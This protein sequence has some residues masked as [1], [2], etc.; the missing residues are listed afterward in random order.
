[1]RTAVGLSFVF[2]CA[3]CSDHDRSI[4]RERESAERP[5]A[6]LGQGEPPLDPDGAALTAPGDLR[7]LEYVIPNSLGTCEGDAAYPHDP[8]VD[9]ATGLVYYT[10]TYASCVGQFDPATLEFRAWPTAA[11]AAEP[12]GI[13]VVGGIVYFTA[14]S[15]NLIGQLDPVSGAEREYPSEAPAPHT[16]AAQAGALWFTA[17][18]GK[19]GR[20]DPV[21]AALQSFSFSSETTNPYGIAPAPDGSLWVALFGTNR[22]ARI[23]TSTDPPTSEEFL[24]PAG[25]ARPRRIA[26]DAEGTVWY[27]DYARRALGSMRPAAAEGEQFREFPTPAGGRPYGIAIGPDGHVWYDDSDSGEIVGF[28]AATETV[29]ARLALTT[30]NPGPVRNMDVDEARQRIW[31]ALS[32][33]GRLGVIQF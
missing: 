24:L 14:Q 7:V 1:M 23:D 17:G 5:P 31:L 4:V 15:A 12:H 22:L 6:V 32:D 16:P 11:A 21:T 8:A 25:D 18:A 19:Y 30:A 9:D 2:A 13:V 33:V 10:D 26:V 27:T 20:F 29:L 3:A 28:D